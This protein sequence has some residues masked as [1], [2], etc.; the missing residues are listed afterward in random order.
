MRN[1]YAGTCYRCQKA[2]AVG[3]G[4]FEKHGTGWR[5][6]HAEC[7]IAQRAE[8]SAALQGEKA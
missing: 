4:H 5:T 1:K 6:I 8:K 2:V 7:A 3:A